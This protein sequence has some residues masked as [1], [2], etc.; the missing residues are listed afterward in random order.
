MGGSEGE[1][2]NKE[3]GEDDDEEINIKAEESDLGDGIEK[4]EGLQAL[5]EGSGAG[6]GHGE[7]NDEGDK[8]G[9]EDGEEAEFKNIEEINE[10]D[11]A[12]GGAHGA[13]EGDSGG[14]LVDDVGKSEG[15]DNDSSDKQD[16][17]KEIKH[18]AEGAEEVAN[19]SSVSK[20]GLSSKRNGFEIG[21]F[22]G[23]V[24]GSESDGIIRIMEDG[25]GVG[26]GVWFPGVK[27][28]MFIAYFFVSDDEIRIFAQVVLD[29]SIV[30]SN[31]LSTGFGDHVFDIAGGFAG[32]VVN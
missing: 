19:A 15:S 13:V 5:A 17:L 9:S 25:D 4:V 26:V 18:E 20:D 22:G 24:G 23:V 14:I 29:R 32:A 1:G 11:I 21:I 2:S 7:N 30:G 31:R 27:I 8:E 12:S 6:E 10:V 28:L 16:D 3:D